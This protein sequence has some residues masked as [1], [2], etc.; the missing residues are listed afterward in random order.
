MTAHELVAQWFTKP[1]QGVASNMRF[2]TTA[3]IDLLRSL[4]EQDAE[5]AAAVRAGLGRSFTW[6]PSGRDKYVIT[7]GPAGRRNTILRLAN[8]RAVGAGSL[9]E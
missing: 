5:G 1:Q 3:Q 9:F 8:I 4:C 2:I 6:M 7:E